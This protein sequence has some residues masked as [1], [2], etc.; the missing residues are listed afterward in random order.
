MRKLLLM[1][2]AFLFMTGSLLAQKT[3][4]GKVTDDKGSPLANVSVVVKGTSTGT[5]T[6]ADGTYSLT[7]PSNARVLVFSSVDMSPEEITIGSQ[8][9]ISVTL[10]ATDKSLTEVVVTGYTREKKSQFVG[11]ATTLSSK[12][13]E[14]VPVGAFDQALQGR[15]PGLQ[16]SSGSGQPGTSATITIRGVKTLTGAVTAQQLQPLYVID[17]VPFPAY[18]MS[19]INPND[20]ESIT[21]LKDASAAALY[22]ARGGLGVIVITTKRGK[23]GTANISYRTQI[24]ITNPPNWNKFDMMNT[25][26]I[27]QYEERLGMAGFPTNTPGWVYSKNNPAYAGLPATSPVATPYSASQARYDFMLDSIGKINMFYPDILFRKGLSQT[28]ELNVSGGAERTRFFLSAGYFDQKGTD[29]SSQLKRYTAR[30]NLDF[31]ADKFSVQFNNTFGYSI[32]NYSEGEW[33]GNSARNSFQ[34]AWRAKPYENPYRADGSLIFGANTTLALKQIGNVLEGIDNSLLRQNQVKINS[35]LTVAYKL[36]PYITLKNTLGLDV[37][38]DRWQRFINPASYIGSLQTLGAS[39][40]NSE[41]Y[42]LNANLINTSAAV[43]NKRFANVHEVDAG[44]Y[45]EVVRGYQKALGFTMYNLDPR[46]N[47]TGQNAGPLPVAQTQQFAT[48]AKSE[49]GIRS[50]FGTARYTYNNRYTLNANIRR[51][52]TSRIANDQNKEI[53]TWSAGAIWN[54]MEEGFMKNQNILSDLRVRASYGAVPNIGSIGTGAYA[55]GGGLVTVTN[56]LGPQVPAFGSAI[57]AGSSV[58]GQAPTTPGNPNLKI[59]TVQKFNIGADFAFFKNRL[60]FIVDV[61]HEK[62]VDLFVANPIS[63]TAGFG[64]ATIQIN[65]GTMSNKGIEISASG[66]IVKTTNF[67]V[68]LGINHAINKNNI[69]DLGSVTEIPS[70]T[71]ILREGLP[72]GA[73]YAQHYLGADPTTGRPRFYKQDGTETFNPSE[74]GLFATFGTFMPKHVGG[75]TADIRFKAIT[76]SALFSYQLDVSR[77]NNIENWIT[78]GIIGYHAAVNASRR[79]LTMQWQKPGDNAYYQSPAYDR[80]FT[81]SDISDAKFLRFR[82]L[83]LAYNIPQLNIMKTKIIKSARFYVQMQNIAIWSPWKGPDPEDNNNISLN[84]FPNP[85]MFVTG[86][87]INF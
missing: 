39:G 48:S 46:L 80:G 45:F 49:F 51:D 40:I 37:A 63:A 19:T 22:G 52:G 34:M 20:F 85:R 36:L 61:Y 11:S 84:E 65:A 21:V 41:A 72:Y 54:A 55:G 5:V 26:E 24:G 83:N 1:L 23:A 17:G 75:F 73:H 9:N 86:I 35:G 33:L 64:Q 13:V 66:D 71:F 27:L 29:L 58:S 87:D 12:V 69:D 50:Y 53:T 2:T 8:S 67:E 81:S 76:L 15:A 18:D 6:K 42:K 43:F 30:F 16:V 7:V 79:M 82:N 4:T 68:T 38:D 32:S 60:R 47:Q 59:E 62:T 77:Y 78:R 28:H 31:T 57:Y 74:A 70:G 44:V 25:T 3:I 10:K 14:T 56:Y